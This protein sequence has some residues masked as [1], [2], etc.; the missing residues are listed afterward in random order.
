MIQLL[1]WQPAER[2]SQPAIKLGTWHTKKLLQNVLTQEII[3]IKSENR[4]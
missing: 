2:C 3:L 4:A 1:K